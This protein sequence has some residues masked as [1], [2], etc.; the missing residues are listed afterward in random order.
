[1]SSRLW[2]VCGFCVYI[3]THTNT[4]YG[5]IYI[6]T[7]IHTQIYMVRT[8][9]EPHV[10]T[11]TYTQ[12]DTHKVWCCV[13]LQAT[14]GGQAT[15]LVWRKGHHVHW[16]P[17]LTS[18]PF[19]SLQGTKTKLAMKLILLFWVSF[20]TL[21]GFWFFLNLEKWLLLFCFS[22]GNLCGWPGWQAQ[23]LLYKRCFLYFMEVD[24]GEQDFLEISQ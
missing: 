12:A 4:H 2:Y 24:P 10:Y 3:H 9:Y 7:H 14:V 6:H 16:R 17:A 13:W 22:S 8:I 5:C 18:W 21:E 11:H 23:W 15:Y 20:E 1:M 19:C